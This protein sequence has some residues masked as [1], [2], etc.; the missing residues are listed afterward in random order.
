MVA[1]DGDGPLL[2]HGEIGLASFSIF[3]K[4]VNEHL[5]LL[6]YK[7]QKKVSGSLQPWEPYLDP[8]LWEWPVML[9]QALNP[10]WQLT[11]AIGATQ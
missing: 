6:L 5:T 1:S 2:L 3:F 9:L 4:F 8:T 11:L 10:A 7:Y